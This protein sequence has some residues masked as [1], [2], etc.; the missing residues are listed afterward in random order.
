MNNEWLDRVAEGVRGIQGIQEKTKAAPTWL[1]VK[2]PSGASRRSHVAHFSQLG[3]HKTWK[4]G[5]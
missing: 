1:W 5:A 2:I 3:T 4:E